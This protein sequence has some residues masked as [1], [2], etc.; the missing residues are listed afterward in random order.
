MSGFGAFLA[1]ALN[2]YATGKRAKDART[3]AAA[4][5]QPMGIR[6]QNEPPE[7]Q[8]A[9]GWGIGRPAAVDGQSREV[10]QLLSLIDQREGSGNY[11]TLFAH[12]QNG[13]RYDGMKA[14]EMTLGQLYE[15]TDPNGDY[16]KFVAAN[17]GGTVSTPV[18]RYQIVGS[19]LR[20][21]ATK[22]GLDENTK[23]TPEIQDKMAA[24]LA[25]RRLRRAGGD[26][27]AQLRQFRNEWAGFHKVPDDVLLAAIRQYQANGLA[28]PQPSM[29]AVR[30]A[31]TS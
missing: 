2:G 6:P 30:P 19:T 1:G 18:G 5:P 27:N 14:S 25:D 23:F 7:P 26:A 11:D 21:I 16:G 13:G 10:P 15:F 17:N 20:E 12:S 24:H 9:Q 8:R 3:A 28:L 31:P 4:A 22:L 29:G